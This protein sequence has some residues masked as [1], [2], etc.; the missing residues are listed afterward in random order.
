M[1]ARFQLNKSQ[2]QDLRIL[3][4]L[5]DGQLENIQRKVDEFNQT[6]LSPESLAEHISDICGNDT[7]LHFVRMLLSLTTISLQSMLGVE[8]VVSG[9]QDG[10]PVDSNWTEEELSTWQNRRTILV[11]L[12]SSKILRRAATAI[13]LTYEYTN[14]FRRARV[15][16]DIRP[17][18]SESGEEIDGAVI[19]HTLHLVYDSLDGDHELSVALDFLDI[20]K[21]KEQ[22]D[23]AII[24]AET[25]Q[26]V[27]RDSAGVSTVISGAQYNE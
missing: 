27:M 4:D 5:N 23:R 22:C 9:I 20:K 12:L 16:T 17:I 13:D 1:S 8:G 14:L 18:F 21:L 26:K 3:I 7:A 6:V 25:S 15:L 24:K 11:D 2:I 10:L 19:S